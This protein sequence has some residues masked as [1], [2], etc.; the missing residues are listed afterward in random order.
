M[1]KIISFEI[2]N[3]KFDDLDPLDA[4][5]FVAHRFCSTSVF[6]LPNEKAEIRPDK[7]FIF[8]GAFGLIGEEVIRMN[9]DAIKDVVSGVCLPMSGIR[10]SYGVNSVKN[11]LAQVESQR[12]LLLSSPR[13]PQR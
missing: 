5:W 6:Y 1:V 2:I 11:G 4:S 9:D 3:L 13:K 10:H 7:E 12:K 8:E